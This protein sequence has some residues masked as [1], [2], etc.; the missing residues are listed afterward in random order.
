MDFSNNAKEKIKAKK[1]VLTAMVRLANPMLAEII[2]KCGAESITID[3]EHFAFTDNDIV[4]LIRAI[5]GA[6]AEAM[7]RVNQKDTG[8]IYRT[9]DM[10]ADGILVP[11]VSGLAEARNVI[12]AAKYPPEGNRGCCPITRGADFGMGVDVHEY[13]KKIND[14]IQVTLMIEDHQ[15]LDELDEI[16]KLSGVDQFAIGPSDFSGSY[17][18]P[19]KSSDPD[20]KKDM[21]ESYAKII[22]TGY[23][24]SGLAYTPDAAEKALSEGKTVLNI[25]SDLQMLTKCFTKYISMAEEAAK[26]CGVERT[27]HTLKEKFKNKEF[28]IVPFIRIAEPAIAEMAIMAGADGIIIDNEHYA[29]SDSELINMIRATH[30]RGG[31]AIVRVYDKSKG[32]IGRI[33]DMGAD[34]IMAPQVS[35]YEEALEIIDFVKFPSEGHRG[36][37]PITPGAD[38]GLGE[39][40]KDYA[41]RKNEETI[42]GIMIET[43]AAYEDLDR[44]L[45]LGD[46]VDYLTIGPSDLSASYGTPGCYDN[47]EVVSAIDSIVKKTKDSKIALMT[48]A[49]NKE[50][51]KHDIQAGTRM[52][53]P[54]SDI[55]YMIWGFSELIAEIKKRISDKN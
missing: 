12:K 53:C 1:P 39:T 43:K 23:P 40:P 37:C 31:K 32:G 8:T 26:E 48:I 52:M 25:G 50:A 3:N 29:F 18:R 16:L 13:Y 41:V 51:M 35:S 34:G 11:N 55:Q 14:K 15:V 2:A 38:Y 44:I 36:F 24:A 19:G 7:V 42:V 46:Q 10:G 6:G 4:N 49:S 20:I 17:G 30:A 54:G 9:L 33:L 45:T 27:N 5:H 28:T 47:P 22:A 21:D